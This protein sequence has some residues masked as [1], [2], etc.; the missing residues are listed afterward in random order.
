M[1]KIFYNE[2]S[3][4]KMGWEPEWFGADDFDDDLIEKIQ[5]KIELLKKNR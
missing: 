4:A 1:D 3:A 2:A 5:K